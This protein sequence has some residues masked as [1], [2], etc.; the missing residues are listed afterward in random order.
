MKNRIFELIKKIWLKL[1]RMAG[2]NQVQVSLEADQIQASLELAQVAAAQASL[3]AANLTIQKGE[4]AASL[5]EY[6]RAISMN[7]NLS[8]AYFY[9]G[10]A[11]A[12]QGRYEEAIKDYYKAIDLQLDFPALYRNLGKSLEQSGHRE[13]A[14]KM[15]IKSLAMQPEQK[16]LYAILYFNIKIELEKNEAAYPSML[17]LYA[18]Y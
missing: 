17:S 12:V 6:D 10:N 8:G 18:E 7:P 14:I 13:E 11:L 9:R 1:K 4:V 3:D 2:L 15:Y 16:D 5:K